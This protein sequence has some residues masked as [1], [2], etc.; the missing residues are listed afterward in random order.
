DSLAAVLEPSDLRIAALAALSQ[1]EA[2]RGH[3]AEA[4]SAL[5]LA[6]D[7]S[8]AAPN[9]ISAAT[10][11]E[12]LYHQGKLRSH[13][14]RFAEA[15]ELLAAALVARREAGGDGLEATNALG[16]VALERGASDVARSHFE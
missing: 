7:A 5:E 14:R 11:S 6:H 4:E 16:I 12:V 2:E 10:R 9:G 1:L 15:A 13:Q 8:R 3:L